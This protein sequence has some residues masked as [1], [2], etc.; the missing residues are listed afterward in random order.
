[1]VHDRVP[2][3]EPRARPRWHSRALGLAF[4]PSAATSRTST[5][6]CRPG[7]IDIYD[8]LFAVSVADAEH[9]VAAG[10]WGSVYV[11]DDGGADLEEGR[12]RHAPAALR[13]VD[14]GREARL[15]GRPG[16]HDPA[17]RGRRPH[18]DARSRTT[19]WRRTRTSSACRRSTRTR[20]GR[21]ASG[22]AAS[23][24]TTA[25]RAGR[26]ARSRSTS[27]TRSSSGS[28][29]PSRTRCARARRSTRTSAS[30]TSTACRDV[31]A[32]L[33]HRR[34]RLHLPHR[35]R[36]ARPGSAARSSRTSRCRRSRCATTRSRSPKRTPR[37]SRE[38][39]KKIIDL[40]HLNVAIE[41]VAS[42]AEIAEFGQEDDPTPLFEILEARVQ[43]VSAVLE[44]A[45]LLSDRI[46]KRGSPPWD[47][48]DFLDDDPE[49]L[50][51]YLASRKADAP[52]ISVTIAQNPYL[53]TVRFANTERGLHR[54][55]RRRRAACRSDGGRNWEYRDTGR[56]QA[57][58][59]LFPVDGPRDRRRRE[60][61]RARVDRPRRHVDARRTKGFPTIFTFMRDIWFA[62][63]RQERLHRRRARQ[64]APH[65]RR[66][67][68]NW[69]TVLPPPDHR[70]AAGRLS[71]DR[72]AGA[73]AAS[74]SKSPS[75]RY[76][77]DRSEPAT[78][79]LPLERPC[80]AA[81]V[82]TSSIAGSAR[83]AAVRARGRSAGEVPRARHGARVTRRTR[84][85]AWRD[86]SAQPR[87]L[88]VDD[89]R[90]D[91]EV[92]RDAIGDWRA[93]ETAGS[94]E[95]GARARCAREPFDLVLTRPPSARALGPRPARA[96]A[97]RAPRHRRHPDHRARLGRQRRPGAAHGRGR[98][99]RTSRCAPTS[100]R[101]WCDAR[102]IAAG[103]RPRTST[104]AICSRPSRTAARSP[105]RSSRPR[106][107]RSRSTC[108]SRGSR[109]ARG[110]RD[111]PPRRES[112]LRRRGVARLPRA[113]ER[114]PARRVR[115][116]EADR[117]RGARPRRGARRA[118][119]CTTCC[120]RAGVAAGRMLIVP[121][122]GRA[123]EGGVLLV[124]EVERAVPRR[125]SSRSR[126]S[127]RRRRRPR[128]RTPSA[129][130]R[131]RSA[132]S[133]TTSPAST[134]RAT[135][136][137]A[138]DHEIRRAE[139]YGIAALAAVPR[140]RPLQAGERP[141]RPPGRLAH[142]A[143]A[144]RGARAAASARWTRWRA[145]AAT[146]SR[147]CSSTPASRAGLEIAERIRTAVARA[148][149]ETRGG[150]RR[151]RSRSA[152][153]SRPS[154]RTAAPPR[155]LIDMADK[156]M[157]RAKSL[158]RDRVCSASEL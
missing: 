49:F 56:K 138:L 55:P 85:S 152:S 78:S 67:R 76:R 1:M 96:R 18:L 110:A 136:F 116:R 125:R 51:R 119:R 4:V 135:C 63:G 17:H 39:A 114:A 120:A 100:S 108:C 28:R 79:A 21:S 86:G 143:P 89:T 36:A 130:T 65:R 13:R 145:T 15:G 84:A 71:C 87:V 45:G 93:I 7:E 81:S 29:R 11:S 144:L 92:A 33:D 10:Y 24:P 14:G 38:F 105:R 8:D 61:L 154:R 106:S 118:D 22:A 54:G 112:R 16:R 150:G 59:S 128:C 77:G 30:P 147:S 151:C 73:C 132:P 148:L 99:P 62:P 41:P 113:R 94:A 103:S 102:S 104:C 34:V 140:H 46:R 131:R 111:L 75:P 6:R 48:E 69:K 134:T 88:I 82:G 72:S 37:R 42:A 107:T 68:Q 153:A 146:S 27:C 32:L 60:G 126:G 91:R 40:P 158:G 122:H 5:R 115:G 47:Y 97:R 52:G 139:R 9:V 90:F 141:P 3:S 23:S 26:T 64:R 156:A 35:Q 83:R 121:L 19:R 57:I 74:A 80:T 124:P 43:A 2:P 123:S 133:S 95:A 98:L 149:F 117:R 20:R 58:F 101:W 44:E 50:R 53:F 70:T 12:D 66:R 31:D 155:A 109:R 142:A 25:A 137:T 129:T 157:Y 127:S